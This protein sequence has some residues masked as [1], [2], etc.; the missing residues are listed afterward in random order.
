M[1]VATHF[2]DASVLPFCHIQLFRSP[3]VLSLRANLFSCVCG[4]LLLV[5]RAMVVSISQIAT[6]DQAKTWLE[7]FVRG[8]RQ[9]LIAGS[10]SALIFTTVSMPFDT[11][12]TRVQQV[13]V[14]L[15]LCVCMCMCVAHA[16]EWY[17]SKTLEERISLEEQVS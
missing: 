7:H 2:G 13:C 16:R 17:G 11:V 3:N 1:W 15:C 6:Y 8:F 10:I 14:C 12:K 9:H 5:L 4:K